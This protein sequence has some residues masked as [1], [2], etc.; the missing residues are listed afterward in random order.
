M[1]NSLKP[2]L[3]SVGGVPTADT[4]VSVAPMTSAPSSPSKIVVRVGG[5]VQDCAVYKSSPVANTGALKAAE[6]YAAAVARIAEGVADETIRDLFD[7]RHGFSCEEMRE[8]GHVSDYVSLSD[9]STITGYRSY[10]MRTALSNVIGDGKPVR[11]ESAAHETKPVKTLHRDCKFVPI[12]EPL[13][14]KDKKGDIVEIRIE[15]KRDEYIDGVMH[16]VL[17]CSVQRLYIVHRDDGSSYEDRMYVRYIYNNTSVST[18]NTEVKST[19]TT[20]EEAVAAKTRFQRTGQ[21]GASE[22]PIRLMITDMEKT[23]SFMIAFNAERIV[24]YCLDDTVTEYRITSCKAIRS[25]TPR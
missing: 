24:L 22:A 14:T 5:A 16:H 4:G 8:P 23:P 9:F 20:S 7:K 17:K 12:R 1:S 21:Q 13:L 15:Y 25:A 3:S 19:G 6:D 11:T 10:P 2:I 18:I